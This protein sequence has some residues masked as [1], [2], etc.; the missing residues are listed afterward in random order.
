MSQ[1]GT[2]RR[3]GR[4]GTRI[5]VLPAVDT[6]SVWNKI[7]KDTDTIAEL[8]LID[9]EFIDGKQTQEEVARANRM[10]AEL[11]NEYVGRP[12]FEWTEPVTVL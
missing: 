2:P 8:V 4:G 12:Y 11:K 6:G 5:R 7:E 1:W 9:I 10:L 3:F